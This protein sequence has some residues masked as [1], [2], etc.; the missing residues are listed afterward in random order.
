MTTSLVALLDE[1][2]WVSC[3]VEVERPTQ[4]GGVEWAALPVILKTSRTPIVMQVDEFAPSQDWEVISS[5]WDGSCTEAQFW[6]ALASE[7]LVFHAG[8]R[9]ARI[10]PHQIPD[11]RRRTIGC[12]PVASEILP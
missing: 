3:T 5:E 1:H 7:A 11:F 12:R 4:D 9:H 2:T 8:S 10:L 6:P